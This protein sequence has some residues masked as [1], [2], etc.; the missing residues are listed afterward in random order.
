MD[1]HVVKIL[2]GVKKER[3]M[4]LSSAVYVLISVHI[5]ARSVGIHQ[6]GAVLGSVRLG[7]LEVFG[8]VSSQ[9]LQCAEC[10]SADS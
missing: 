10:T 8:P 7:P 5:D 1:F 2:Q 9:Q 4:G 3:Y 6:G